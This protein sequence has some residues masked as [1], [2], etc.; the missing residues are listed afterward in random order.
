MEHENPP[1]FQSGSQEGLRW[2]QSLALF[3]AT[4]AA[5]FAY[6]SCTAIY[7]AFAVGDVPSIWP[8]TPFLAS[9]VLLA[10]SCVTLWKRDWIWSASLAF[11]ALA[12]FI[13]GMPDR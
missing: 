1:E 12:T 2:N 10:G 6:I 5:F 11:L 13:G 4:F 8:G 3:I 7:R 9:S